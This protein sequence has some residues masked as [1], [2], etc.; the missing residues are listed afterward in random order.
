MLEEVPF[1]LIFDQMLMMAAFP[2]ASHARYFP[3]NILGQLKHVSNDGKS[4]SV[5]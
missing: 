1:L 3:S 2:P 5:L 4:C